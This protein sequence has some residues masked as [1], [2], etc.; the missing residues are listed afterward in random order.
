MTAESAKKSNK[1]VVILVVLVVTLVA[2]VGAGG[3]WFFLLKEEAK[4]EKV[5]VEEPKKKVA[6]YVQLGTTGTPPYFITNFPS[7]DRG[8]ER[9]MQVYAEART[10]EPEIETALQKHMPLVVHG[11]GELFLSQTLVDMESLEGKE[12]LRIKATEV[13]NNILQEQIGKPGIEEIL[14]TNFITL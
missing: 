12:R 5:V 13:V 11:L 3:V 10:F 8:T 6:I 1:L 4:V 14:F 9:F 7:E 2:I